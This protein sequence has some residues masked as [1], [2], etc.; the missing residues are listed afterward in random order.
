MRDPPRHGHTNAV[1]EAGNLRAVDEQDMQNHL[2]RLQLE[3]SI[4]NSDIEPEH[5]TE[6]I[7]NCSIH[8]YQARKLAR[9]RVQTKWSEAVMYPGEK[10]YHDCYKG[11]TLFSSNPYQFVS[12][13]SAGIIGTSGFAATSM[14]GATGFYGMARPDPYNYTRSLERTLR[15]NAS[16]NA[17]AQASIDAKEPKSS[18]WIVNEPAPLSPD[19]DSATTSPSGNEKRVKASRLSNLRKAFSIKTSE[20]RVAE[21]KLKIFS[22]GEGLRIEILNEENGRW[23]NKEWRDLVMGYQEHVGMAQKIADLRA[24]CPI[25]YLHLLRAGYFEPIPVE[26]AN[27]ASN[28]LKFRIEASAGWRG[29]TPT[30]RGFEDTAEERLYWVLN[31]REGSG[32]PRLKP[33]PISA[34]AMARARMASAVPPPIEY[35][36]PN[37]V[38]HTQHKSDDYSKQVL[39]GPFKPS[40]VPGSPSDDTM[41]LLDVSG[42]M[43]FQPVRPVYQQALI[44]GYERSNQP[45]NKDLAR[46]T[47]RRFTDTMIHYDQNSTGYQLVTFHDR[48]DYIGVINHENFDEMWNHVVFGGRTRVMTGWQLVKNL[49]FQKHSESAS[50]HPVYGWQAGPKTPKLRLLLLL[51]GEA[52]DMDEFELDLL[53]LS[54][55]HVTIFLIGVDGCPHHHRHANELQRISEVNPH[56]SFVDS[57]GNTPERFITHELLKRH[58]GYDF[59]MSEFEELERLPSYDELEGG[60]AATGARTGSNVLS[61]SPLKG[62]VKA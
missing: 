45:K 13:Y 3:Y 55:V 36:S 51:D 59:T 20:E 37:D 40:D 39:P 38:C 14:Y 21:K 57:Q 32:G 6:F 22:K 25:Q 30:W 16:L 48:A 56:V 8:M 5:D 35:Y 9:L 4:Y 19:D 11:A 34:M 15:L 49:H 12:S 10:A 1:I 52:S 31:H 23:A 29:I 53:S 2:Q 27:L 26:W 33:D 28:P 44:T 47:I 54:W 24:R 7:C 62:S 50:Y 18:I 58:L 17:S 41:L 61:S 46:A 60:G 43:G 42:S